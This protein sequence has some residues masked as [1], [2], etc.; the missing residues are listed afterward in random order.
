MLW[1]SDVVEDVR[2]V[3]PGREAF[4]ATASVSVSSVWQRGMD[5]MDWG[6]HRFFASV[7]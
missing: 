7:T 2:G 6:V 3:A 1:Y 4:A 5:S